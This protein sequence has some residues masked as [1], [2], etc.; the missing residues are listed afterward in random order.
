MGSLPHTNAPVMAV[1]LIISLVDLSQ[2]YHVVDC[3]IT[4]DYRS[5]HGAT[6]SISESM[7]VCGHG[8]DDASGAASENRAF[9][10]CGNTDAPGAH[11][12]RRWDG[13][14]LNR[15]RH[16]S[17]ASIAPAPFANRGTIQREV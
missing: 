3:K 12:G 16:L 2:S 7:R 8:A 1:A 5:L 14:E 13:A 10:D 11:R 6:T 4:T 9:V 17:T 15:R